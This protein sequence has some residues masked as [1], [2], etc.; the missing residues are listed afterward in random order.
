[1]LGQ[2]DTS[3]PPVGVTAGQRWLARL[4]F[5]AAFAAIVVLLVFG[6]LAS[7]VLILV[8][9]IGLSIA[10]AAFWGFL[11]T[12]GVR[13]WILAVV[14]VAA[15][16]AVLIWYAVE[17]LVWLVAVVLALVAL[18]G[19]AGRTAL[20]KARPWTG[21]TEYD[22][23]PP[24]R[25]FVI[26]NPRSGGGKVPR[27]GLQAKAEALG[28]E[29]AL[30]EGP[31]EVDVVALARRAVARGADLLGVAGGDGTQALV[32]GV[33]AE[34]DI[35][36]MVISAGTRNHFALDLGLDRDDP[37]ASLDALTDGV[38]LHVDL[39]LIGDRTFVNN[40]SFGAYAEIVQS[41]AYRDD[42]AG[43][44]LRMLP[45]LLT[46]HQ[47]PHLRVLV[48]G[49]PVLDGPQAVLVSNN[50]YGTGDT[51]GM[52]RRARL[53]SGRLGMVAVKVVNARQAADLMRGTRAAGLTVHSA[54]EVVIDADAGTVP[55]GIDGEAVVMAVPVRCATRPGALRVRVP[56]HR[57]GLPTYRPALDWPH[58]AHL[59]G[60]S[61]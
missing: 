31:G 48:D 24:A 17:G 56:R 13:R 14:V 45:E 52:G 35:P 4:A 1:M 54:T 43:T 49:R 5:A 40:A 27:F 6:V 58:L 34:H 18:A 19:V 42:K 16:V 59:A 46:G 29:V 3:A 2:D 50:P 44:T 9:V 12:R 38:E 28:A 60:W 8:S 15:P 33:A 23:P 51:A 22:T 47:G 57:P 61:R 53:D 41:P 10:L 7:A 39:G 36:F 25:P 30:L 21:M 32:A 26:M 37:A 11:T 55:V 20:A